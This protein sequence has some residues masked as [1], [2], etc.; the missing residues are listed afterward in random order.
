[1]G[2]VPKMSLLDGLAGG[3]V[4]VLGKDPILGNDPYDESGVVWEGDAFPSRRAPE[5]PNGINFR[6][7]AS[8]ASSSW[9]WKMVNK[10]YKI[11]R[12][13]HTAPG[14]AIACVCV[15]PEGGCRTGS[16]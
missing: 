5:P 2:L 6:L 13:L 16:L 11:I 9:L 15:V 8:S 12:L 1:V 4:P 14:M 3:G 10:R 7:L